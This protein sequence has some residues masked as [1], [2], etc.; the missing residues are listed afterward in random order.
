M[1]TCA[2]ATC[3][4]E[5]TP[6]SFIHRFCSARCRRL[7][8]GDEWGWVR[9]EALE[10][11]EHQCQECGSVEC[12]QVHHIT[13]V[14]MGG[15]SSLENVTTL[16]RPCH[17]AVHRSWAKWRTTPADNGKN[18]RSIYANTNTAGV[19]SRAAA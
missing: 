7:A 13:P 5:F 19:R 18:E 1:I 2:N 11:D 4:N 6:R 10:R 16:C 12:L 3:S 15:E 17:Q 9:E 8:R 14:C